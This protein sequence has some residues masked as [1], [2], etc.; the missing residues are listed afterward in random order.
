[1]NPMLYSNSPLQYTEFS[2]KWNRYSVRKQKYSEMREK[3]DNIQKSW[4]NNL[5]VRRHQLNEKLLI[6]S[7]S[8]EV[9]MNSMKLIRARNY[10]VLAKERPSVK[11]HPNFLDITEEYRQWMDQHVRNY[12][13][14]IWDKIGSNVV[15]QVKFIKH[16][17]RK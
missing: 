3:M 17:T 8:N 14:E 13:T 6:S 16:L 1:M 10:T 15:Q 9:Y 2:G 5:N 12:A 7:H 4:L 11:L